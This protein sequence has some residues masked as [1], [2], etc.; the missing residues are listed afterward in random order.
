MEGLRQVGMSSKWSKDLNQRGFDFLGHTGNYLA[1]EEFEYIMKYATFIPLGLP[2][3]VQQRASIRKPFKFINSKISNHFKK[4]TM[5][6]FSSIGFQVT[7]RDELNSLV[8]EAYSL[9]QSIPVA[10]GRYLIYTDP[11]GAE[12][13]I[14]INAQ[15]ELIGANR[16]SKGKAGGRFV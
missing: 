5:S 7:S 3:V 9:G 10:N 2:G 6:H 14:Q 16:I 11:S 1:P 4:L 15:N 13:W 8:Q 12:L